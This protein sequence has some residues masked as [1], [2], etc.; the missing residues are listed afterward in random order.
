MLRDASGRRVRGF[1][2]GVARGE[3]CGMG[4]AGGHLRGAVLGKLLAQNGDN[5]FTEQVELFQQ[6]FSGTP[7]PSTLNSCRW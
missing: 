6:L 4:G 2:L 7:T 1:G 5:L 3:P